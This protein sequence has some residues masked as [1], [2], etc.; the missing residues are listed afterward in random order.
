MCEVWTHLWSGI[1]LNVWYCNVLVTKQKL[2][3]ISSIIALKNKD[4]DSIHY[5]WHW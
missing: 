2:L 5:D 1:A 4:K 3:Q